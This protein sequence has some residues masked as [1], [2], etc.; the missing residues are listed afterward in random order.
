M[1]NIYSVPNS[2]QYIVAACCNAGTVHG[3]GGTVLGKLQY[4][5]HNI[6]VF[7]LADDNEQTTEIQQLKS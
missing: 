1:H 2:A 6:N 3:T 4:C 5:C 7:V